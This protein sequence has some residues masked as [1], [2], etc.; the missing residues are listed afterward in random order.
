MT[1]PQNHGASGS[2]TRPDVFDD[3][4]IPVSQRLGNFS[5]SVFG[6]VFNPNTIK[7]GI[8]VFAGVCAAINLSGYYD[9]GTQLMSIKLDEYGREIPVNA[10]VGERIISSLV[11]IPLIGQL[12][13]W[14]DK[15]TGDLAALVIAIGAWFFIQGLEIAS[16]FYLYFPEAAENLLF[17]LNRKRYEAPA[18]NPG[19]KKAYKLATGSTN[20]I[21]RWLAIIGFVAYIVDAYTMHLSRAWTDHLG[22]PLWLNVLWNSLAVVGVELS[23]LLYRGYKAVTLSAAEKAERDTSR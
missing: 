19:A 5:D 4:N 6:F 15:L 2:K 13:L 7:F 22:N 14:L 10:P 1:N 18:N 16:R 17:K 12:I 21:L 9:V 20:L 23:M 3:E 8:L 11:R